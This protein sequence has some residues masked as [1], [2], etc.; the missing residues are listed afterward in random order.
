MTPSASVQSHLFFLVIFSTL[1]HTKYSQ[2]QPSPSSSSSMDFFFITLHLLLHLLYSSPTSAALPACKSTCGSLPVKYPLGT[3][4]GCGSPRFHPSVSCSSSDQLLL[5]THTGSYPITSISYPTSTLTISPPLMSTCSS[6]HSSPDFGLDW[7]T[8]FQ[9]GPSI[10]LLLSCTT[11]SSSLTFKG[12]PLCDSSNAHLCAAIY[13]CS[14]VVSLGLPLFAPT[15]SCC[16]YSPANLGPHGDLDL[17][18]LKCAGYAPVVSLGEYP[19]D[20]SRWEYGVTL[21]FSDGGLDNYNFATACEACEKSKGA[22]G[23]APPSNYFVCVCKNGVNTSTDC[24]G[25]VDY[26]NSNGYSRKHF[27]LGTIWLVTLLVMILWFYL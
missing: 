7:A 2:R 25:Q 14:S 11:P 21:Q 13:S 15:N 5:T 10:F 6:M 27:S 19:T 23:Y 9:I 18:G 3:G 12:S 4:P 17:E 1:L 16:V 8:P 24:Y 22:C 20:P 26:W